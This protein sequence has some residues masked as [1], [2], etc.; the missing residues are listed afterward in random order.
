MK[1]LVMLMLTVAMLAVAGIASANPTIWHSPQYNLS[2]VQTINITEIENKNVSLG[3]YV[4][5][6]DTETAVKTALYE[7]ANKH[8][9]YVTE[10][11]AVQAPQQTK[12]KRTP[13]VINLKITVDKLGYETTI[14]PAHY[15]NK[16]EYITTDVYDKRGKKTGEARVPIVKQVYVPDSTYHTAYLSIIY[17]VQDADGTLIFTSRDMRD[18]EGTS[19]PSGMLERASNDFI[20]HLL[21][22]K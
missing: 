15:E 22:S 16:T 7:A 18:R 6:T 19:D 8:D 13:S 1:K 2:K 17:S 12:G 21:K 5:E 3:K 4:A 11:D 20:K 10:A 9:V 14:E